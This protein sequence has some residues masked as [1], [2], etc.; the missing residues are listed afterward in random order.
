MNELDDTKVAAARAE[1][2]DF[3]E[4]FE[5]KACALSLAQTRCAAEKKAIV[6]A[7]ILADDDRAKAADLLKISPRT[8]RHKLQS[9]DIETGVEKKR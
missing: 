9:Y 7:L 3:L 1:A 6:E 8:L 4:N 2:A 5:E